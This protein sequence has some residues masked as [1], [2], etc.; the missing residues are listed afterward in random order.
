MAA[1]VMSQRKVDAVI[2][3]TDRVAANGDVANKIGT[4]AVAILAKHF[5]IP[6]YV[7]APTSSID[8]ALATGKQIPIEERDPAE[9]TNGLGRQTAPTDVDVFNPRFHV[10]PEG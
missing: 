6:F 7:A 4:H 5:N 2:V 9:V 1:T 8:M 10:T 3:G